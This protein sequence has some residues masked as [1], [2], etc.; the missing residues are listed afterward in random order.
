MDLKDELKE[1][2]A[3][4]KNAKATQNAWVFNARKEASDHEMH[5]FLWIILIVVS[6]LSIAGLYTAVL[7]FVTDFV[8]SILSWR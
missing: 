7:W 1:S 8:S 5:R 2:V 6:S 3:E 4:A